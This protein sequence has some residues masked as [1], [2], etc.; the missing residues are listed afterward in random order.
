[1]ILFNGPN[2]PFGRMALATALEQGIEV[3]NKV[4]NVIGAEFLDA[5]NPMRQIPTL[6]L[7]DGRAMFDSRVICAYLCSLR[8]ER[9]LNPIEDCWDIQTR[10]WLAVGLMES[11][12]QQVMELRRPESERSQSALHTYSRRIDKVIE[13]LEGAADRI[14]SNEVR[15]D[16][17]A[18]AIALEY[19]DFRIRRDW[20]DQAPRL[21][22]WLEVESQ[23][24]CLIASQPRDL[25]ASSPNN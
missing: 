1:M 12:V 18:V 10:W 21:S 8:P 6:L 20:R 9:G 5:I 15:I 7:D 17:L 16:R 22:L 24:P 19:V 11:S 25:S 13:R 2:T 14:C 4:I 3:E 23:R